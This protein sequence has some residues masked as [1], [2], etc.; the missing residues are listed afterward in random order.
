MTE[1]GEGEC[2]PTLVE[3]DDAVVEVEGVA[4]PLNVGD[5]EV[6]ALIEDWA[7]ADELDPV[8]AVCIAVVVATVDGEAKLEAEALG[9]AQLLGEALVLLLAVPH[10]LLL[11]DRNALTLS[12]GVALVVR[13]TVSVDDSLRDETAVLLLL[14]HAELVPLLRLLREVDDDAVGDSDEGGLLE[15]VPDREARGVTVAQVLADAP[16]V[17]LA[18][19]DA[20]FEAALLTLGEAELEGEADTDALP[21][22]VTLARVDADA[23]AE[24]ERTP[25]AVSTKDEDMRGLSVRHDV[26]DARD[27]A[28]TLGEVDTEGDLAPLRDGIELA[29]ED[30]TPL[31]VLTSVRVAP[32]VEETLVE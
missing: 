22:E 9:D 5:G 13:T 26:R 18:V 17:A 16:R 32:L 8:L 24:R 20:L 15:V 1:E 2:D 30:E 29:E 4:S 12:D 28:E 3:V 11:R 21:V 23:I 27:V 25:L 31:R 14:L 19:T 7:L 6:A 10:A